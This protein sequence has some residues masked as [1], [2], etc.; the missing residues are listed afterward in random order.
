MLSR[1]LGGTSLKTW[2]TWVCLF[3]SIPVQAES[4]PAETEALST[5][6]AH[7]YYCHDGDTCRVKVANSLWVSVRLAGIDAP[8]VASRGGR[9]KKKNDG[10]T[11]GQDAKEFLNKAVQGKT[12]NLR[13]VDLDPFN[14]PVVVMESEG[15]A[16]N[17]RLIEEGFAE[18]YRGKTKRLDKAP[19]FAAEE[20][21]KKD[22]KGI[23]SLATY[24]SPAAFRK[25]MKQ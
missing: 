24:E 14:R 2:I 21:A 12:V 6:E 17:L 7:V 20:K 3:P 22:K 13:Q 18:V 19:Y 9:G 4:E 8:E 11:M 25:D 23:W 15:K 5:V 10:Q 16:I 1:R